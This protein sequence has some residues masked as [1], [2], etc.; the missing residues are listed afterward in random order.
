MSPTSHTMAMCEGTSLRLIAIAHGDYRG[1]GDTTSSPFSKFEYHK[2]SIL[3]TTAITVFIAELKANL[4]L[5]LY[6]ELFI[7]SVLSF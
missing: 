2:I 7:F 6:F 3:G 1:C 4:L 5:L